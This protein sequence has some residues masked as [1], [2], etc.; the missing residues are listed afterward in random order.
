M[1]AFIVSG[2]LVLSAIALL[3]A[4]KPITSLIVGC[5]QGE[6]RDDVDNTCVKG[7]IPITQI[8]G[9]DYDEVMEVAKQW[10]ERHREY[11]GVT[12]VGVDGHGI[13]V[14]V[15]PDHAADIPREVDGVPIHLM[16]TQIRVGADLMPP[17]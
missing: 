13:R 9:R 7:G 3:G 4:G 12:S 6:Y 1:K 10:G 17:R 2:L 11:K 15:D 14:E 5:G 16:P 8:A